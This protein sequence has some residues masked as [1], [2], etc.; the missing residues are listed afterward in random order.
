MELSRTIGVIE[1]GIGRGLHPGAQLYVSLRGRTVFD[2][3]FGRTEFNGSGVPV[4]PDSLTLWMSAGK[5]LAAISIAQLAAAGKIG[6][7]ERI[8]AHIPAFDRHGKGAITVRH[9]L[10]HTGGFRGPMGSFEPGTWEHQ[11]E[12]ACSLKLEPG[13]VPG[14]KAGYHP[15]SSWFILGELV[16][17]ASGQSYDQYVREHVFGPLGINDAWVGMPH[18]QWDAYGERVAPTLITDPAQKNVVTRLNDPEIN[19]VPRPG[20]NARGPVRALGNVYEALLSPHSAQVSARPTLLSPAEIVTLA[21]RS[22]VGL[23]D[24]TFKCVL[25]WGLGF[26]VDSKEYAGE[27]PY[28]YGPHA[29]PAAF[30]HSGNQSTCAF[31]DPAHGL[32]VA[33]ACTGMPGDAAHDARQKAINAAIYEDLGL[34]P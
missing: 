22:R 25:D 13:W 20:A 3:A 7:E 29:S 5:P 15:G 8:A 2:D 33:W 27:H 6:L 30:G 16:R 9:L 31:A 10:H 18:A 11:V 14:Q 26:L 24:H 12:K 4:T 23:F 34:A 17:V 32:A 19:A 1:A 21:A 28:G